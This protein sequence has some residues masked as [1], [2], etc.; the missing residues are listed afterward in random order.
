MNYRVVIPTAGTGSR[1]ENLTKYINK[2]LLSVANRPTISHLIDLFPVNCEFVIALGHKGNLVRD[3]LELTY[4]DKTFYFVNIEPYQGKGSGLGYTL[5][6]CKQY[7]QQPFVFLSCDTLLDGNIH[8][9]TY[10]WMGYAERDDLLQYRTLYITGDNVTQ[11]CEKGVFKE[12]LWAYP[13]VAGV[14]DYDVFWKS[15]QDGGKDAIHQGETYGLRA[16][17]ETS[18]VSAKKFVWFDT[19]NLEAISLARKA[20]L[21]PNGPNILEKE[22]DAIWFVGDNVI[23]YSD[24]EDFITN[25]IKRAKKLKGYVPEI[26]AHRP[27][28]YC[29]KKVEGDVLSKAITLPIFE[30]FLEKSKSFWL[31]KPLSEDEQ[32]KFQLNCMKFYKIKT[33]ERVRLFYKKFNQMDNAEFINEESMPLLQELLNELDWNWISEGIAGRFHGDFHF[34]NIIYSKKRRTFTFLDWRQDFAGN[35]SIGDIYY[36]LSKINH[37]LIINH[38]VIANEGYS[39]LWKDNK[40]SYDFYRK[41]I[42]VECEQRLYQWM[43]ENNLDVKKVRVLTG[44]IYLNIAALHHHP[45]SILLYAI[46]KRILK[47]ELR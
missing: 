27:N 26:F 46:G 9:P 16:I 45:Y 28:M 44:L 29:Y 19:G 47:R 8:E 35:L 39:V 23:K 7:L 36:D 40:I 2:S 18:T 34:E 6:S 4:P 31:T 22:N 42:L 17:L 32:E 37:G 11:I 12:N 33:F 5:L 38:G 14:Y 10:N 30:R 13:G 25:R 21:K 3:F 1:L 20:Y 41:Q 43:K 15:M 24:D